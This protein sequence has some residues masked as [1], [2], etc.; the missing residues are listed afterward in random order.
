MK[1]YLITIKV[2]TSDHEYYLKP[3]IDFDG[4]IADHKAV[5]EA[6]FKSPVI[7]DKEFCC[8]E[9]P[10]AEHYKWCSFRV[11]YIQEVA[12]EQAQVLEYWL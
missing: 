8:Y 3:L 6:H 7:Y 2:T 1:H 4:D 10:N 12:P 5:L 11:E 9:I